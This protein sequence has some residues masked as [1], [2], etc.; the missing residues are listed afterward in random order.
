[1]IR[2]YLVRHGI[3]APA[4]WGDTVARLGTPL[5]G[6][7][8]NVPDDSRP[9]TAKGRKRFRRAAR[10]F[11]RIGERID[12]LFTSPLVRAV[13]TAEILARVLKRDEVDVLEELRPGVPIAKVL[14]AVAKLVKDGEAVA[15]VGHDP[16][17]SLL[18]VALAQ[19]AQ[20]DGERVTFRK[21]AIVRIDVDA[22]PPS[23]S[24]PRWHL[25]PRVRTIVE[26]LPLVKA[27]ADRPAR[28]RR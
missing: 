2:V 10:A 12:R 27:T 14:A 15:L 16:Q 20:G 6:V 21:G 23:K 26:G 17:M 25:K 3:A 7:P 19:L 24:E 5:D 13:Q 8:D 22:L 9:L 4:S 11:A 1:M 28:A 18:V